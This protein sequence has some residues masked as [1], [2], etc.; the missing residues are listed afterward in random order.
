MKTQADVQRGKV[1][2]PIHQQRVSVHKECYEHYEQLIQLLYQ[3][4]YRKRVN[5]VDN[6]APGFEDKVQT[7]SKLVLSTGSM[8]LELID[9]EYSI[10]TSIHEMYVHDLSVSKAALANVEVRVVCVLYY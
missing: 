5:G 7:L 3:E 9:E 8:L 2:K 10:A 1:L 4:R 6:H